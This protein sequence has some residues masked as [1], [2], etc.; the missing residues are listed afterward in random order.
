MQRILVVDDEEDVREAV[1]QT[2]SK[3]NYDVECVENAE[4]ARE[5][6]LRFKPD[7]IILDIMLPGKSGKDFC[8]ELRQT[9]SVPVIFLSGLDDDVD[10]IVGLE[11]GADD[12][13]TKPF[14]PGELLARVRAVLRR[15]T[16]S[17]QTTSQKPSN[18]TPHTLEHGPICV[19]VQ[20]HVVSVDDGKV[21]VTKTEFGLLKTLMRHPTRVYSRTEL[22]EG[23]YGPGTYVS[24]R[25]INSHIRRLR[26]KL[27]EAGVD[28]IET[29]RGVGYRILIGLEE[30]DC[31]AVP[32][33]ESEER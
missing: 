1:R 6:L 14:H 2:L 16:D 27:E 26:N 13:L 17:E 20:R 24:E 15:T 7:L 19:D 4:H 18:G 28:P 29:V 3:F 22:M 9:H 33:D 25:T 5:S 12:Y 31:E 30:N 32:N 23:A 8:R 21:D 11:L 10:R